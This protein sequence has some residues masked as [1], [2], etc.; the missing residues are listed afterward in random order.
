MAR[1]IIG[2]WQVSAGGVRRTRVAA[3]SAL[4]DISTRGSIAG[5]TIPAH[6]CV[7]ARAVQ[8]CGILAASVVGTRK[9]LVNVTTFYSI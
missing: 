7:G 5:V 4:V 2:S 1:A 8:A 6:A 9:A 3:S